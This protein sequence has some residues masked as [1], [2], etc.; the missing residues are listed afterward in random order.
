[1]SK[2]LVQAM[3]MRKK[4]QTVSDFLWV[5]SEMYQDVIILKGQSFRLSLRHL[6]YL[7]WNHE[8][9]HTTLSSSASSNLWLWI[10]LFLFYSFIFLFFLTFYCDDSWLALVHAIYIYLSIYLLKYY[11]M[12]IVIIMSNCD[13]NLKKW[14]VIFW[15]IIKIM[16]P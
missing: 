3:Q 10:I 11:I 15:A 12:L 7:I 4:Q 6:C 2:S 5:Q 8:R 1:M 13:H 16:L 9:P 14:Y